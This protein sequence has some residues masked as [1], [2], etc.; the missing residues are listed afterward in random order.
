MRDLATVF[1]LTAAFCLSTLSTPGFAATRPD[2]GTGE[3]PKDFKNTSF[4]KW[5]VA[6]RGEPVGGCTVELSSQTRSEDGYYA[7]RQS[8]ECGKYLP[9][10]AVYWE[11]WKGEQIT[12]L[13]RNCKQVME[14]RKRGDAWLAS[15]NV[16]LV[17]AG[18]TR[19]NPRLDPR[20]NTKQL[21][22]QEIDTRRMP[23]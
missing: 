17:R 15:N 18:S 3:I 20:L 8:G 11:M 12:L 21:N 16:A 5:G 7:M 14:L 22:T 6:V 4:G 2:G 13:D 19:N 1:V 10:S 9:S 23:Q